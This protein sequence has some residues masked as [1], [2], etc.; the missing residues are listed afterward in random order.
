MAETKVSALPVATNLATTDELYLVQGGESKRVTLATLFANVPSHL[1][2]KGVFALNSTPQQIANS[3][4]IDAT[5]A[6]T[7]FTTDAVSAAT[8]QNGLVT[9]QFKVVLLKT[10]GQPLTLTGGNLGVATITFEGTGA[11]CQLQWID[12]K[13][14]PIGGTAT[15]L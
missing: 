1:R 8:I 13:W 5:S 11:T 6:T 14:Y 7:I 3:G 2:V 12:N 10:A 4:E 9:G 15:V